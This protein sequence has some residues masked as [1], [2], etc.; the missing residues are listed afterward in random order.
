MLLPRTVPARKGHVVPARKG[1]V[2]PARRG[3]V[4]P[5]KEGYEVTDTLALLVAQPKPKSLAVA[6]PKW[7]MPTPLAEPLEEAEEEPLIVEVEVADDDDDDYPAEIDKDHERF[8]DIVTA[9]REHEQEFE[10]VL[11][12]EQ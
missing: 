3:H 1:H 12:E 6:Q 5:P 11:L 2:V 9:A 7:S 4:V 8:D 10:E